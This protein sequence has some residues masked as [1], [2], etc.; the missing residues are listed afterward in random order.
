[1]IIDLG[2]CEECGDLVAPRYEVEGRELCG[3]CKEAPDWQTRDD[4]SA[5]TTVE[6]SER[7]LR[8]TIEIDLREA[9]D[10]LESVHEWFRNREVAFRGVHRFDDGILTLS[11]QVFGQKQHHVTEKPRSFNRRTNRAPR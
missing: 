2:H 11:T 6:T 3:K 4:L 10:V 5:F 1:M 8:V 9:E 7:T